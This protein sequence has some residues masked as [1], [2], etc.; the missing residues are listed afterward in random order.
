MNHDG[1]NL[2]R[3]IV[4]VLY[5]E[6]NSFFY[7]LF[8]FIERLLHEKSRKVSENIPRMSAEEHRR[9]IC[10]LQTDCS[11]RKVIFWKCSMLLSIIHFRCFDY[12]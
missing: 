1:F 4:L 2:K 8:V 12:E 10:M 5:S 3:K 6:K 9:A 7:L 11:I